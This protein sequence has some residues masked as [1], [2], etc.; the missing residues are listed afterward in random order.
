MAEPNSRATDLRGIREKCRL[1]PLDN[2]ELETLWVDTD[3][4][5]DPHRSLRHVVKTILDE[6][7]DARMLVYGHGGCGKST[8]LNKLL[9]E[10]GDAYFPVTFS[11]RDEM[12]LTAVV[13]EDIV[14]VITE[15]LLA[16]AK[17]N[18]LKVTDS[19]LRPVHDY[20][21]EFTQTSGKSRKSNASVSAKA[22]VGSSFL[23]PLL[24][25][26]AE[27]KGEIKLDAHS[28]ETRVS[29]L[30]KRP[31]DLLAQ[32]N[33]V[34]SAVRNAL[35]NGRRLLLIVE[36]L[37]KLDIAAAHDVFIG[38]ANLLTG[39]ITDIIYTI[40]IFTFHSPDAGVLR[41]RF[42]ADIG[43]PMIKTKDIC[44]QRA[45]GFETVK[46][47]L[48][49]RVDPSAIT[50]KAVDLLIEKTG[51]VL[52]HAFEVLQ[53]AAT[54]NTSSIP[55]TEEQIRYGLQRKQN[56]FWSEINLPDPLPKGLDNVEQLYERLA[57]YAKKQAMGEKV[58]PVGDVVN[59]ALLKSAALVE[60]N[61]E[62]WLGVH[63]LVVD[64]LKEL[65][66]L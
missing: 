30:R 60:Y 44:G 34:I 42:S 51:G 14:L 39:M 16:A 25:L 4:A 33:A 48:H 8:E 13:A 63:P 45:G 3:A 17:D 54:M 28:N 64:N 61:G 10:L 12:S 22:S 62:R 55:L 56:E 9:S 40:P 43:L 58:H 11:I 7:K 35:P 65:G 15:R 1:G 32:A 36:D 66:R 57:E 21:A 46:K 23:A 53:T 20:F 59:Q 19:V 29:K 41:S 27:F 49:H 2:A 31:A 26:F 52:Q 38:H 5:R 18:K 24:K 47:I 50:E 37:D 6:Q